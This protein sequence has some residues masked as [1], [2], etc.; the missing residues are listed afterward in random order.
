MKLY[1]GKPKGEEK[2][3]FNPFPLLCIKR[4]SLA[5]TRLSLPFSPSQ[6]NTNEAKK[7]YKQEITEEKDDLIC[8]PC[9]ISSLVTIVQRGMSRELQKRLEVELLFL[10]LGYPSQILNLH[11]FIFDGFSL[12]L[13]LINR[14]SSLLLVARMTCLATQS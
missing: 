8:L 11:S 5:F 1:I 3:V 4:G 14:L 9:C 6:Q 13:L 2:S 12:F 7:T 10:E